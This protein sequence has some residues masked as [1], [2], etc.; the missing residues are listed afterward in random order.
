MSLKQVGSALSIHGLMGSGRLAVELTPQ[1]LIIADNS[2]QLTLVHQP[3]GV[4]AEEAFRDDAN[5]AQVT[6]AGCGAAMLAE[7][8]ELV[9]LVSQIL[10]PRAVTLQG[11]PLVIDR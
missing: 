7:R 2:L 8:L 5:Q 10:L 4:S 1:G 11:L 6:F 3:A 9:L